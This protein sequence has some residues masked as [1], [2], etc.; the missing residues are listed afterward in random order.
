M[1]DII[2]LLPDS[3]AN[4]IAAGEV[5]QRPASA[6]KELLENSVDAGASLIRLVVKDA[7]RTLI[8]V[9]DN[10][11]G[12][13]E[14]DARMSFERHATSKIR[15]ADDLF[16]IRTK[17]FRGEALASIGAIAQV[18]LRTKQHGE[19]LGTLLVVEGSEVK[20]QEPCNCAEGTSF[21]VKNLFYNVPARRNFL[22]TDAVELRH[23]I[24]EFQRVALPHH[25]IGF[26]LHHNNTELFNLAPCNLRQ[27]IAQIF[28]SNYN[29]R[30]VPVEEET[31]IVKIKGFIGK[32]EFA[33][34]TR[35]EQ[36]FFINERFIR[37]AYL[38]HAVQMAY[39]E[40]LPQDSF[41]SY[42]ILMEVE[43]KSI[44]INIHPT[45]TEVKFE[46]EKFIY[47]ILRSAVKRSLGK[48]NISPTLDFEQET[49]FNVP[50]LPKDKTIHAP[51]IS[52]NPNYNPFAKE[53]LDKI[54]SSKEF[55]KSKFAEKYFSPQTAQGTGE[56]EFGQ[57][58]EK[59]L[60]E[61]AEQKKKNH[62]LHGRYILSHI[63]SGF[64]I[65]DQHAAHERILYERFSDM[66]EKQKAHSQQLLFPQHITFNQSDF[67]LA[68]ELLSEMRALGFDIEEFGKSTFIVQGVP[69]IVPE[70]NARQLLENLME[71]YKQNL[72]GLKFE[73]RESLARAM[74]QHTAIRPGKTL[75][76]QEMDAL[77]DELFACK[78]PY[79]SPSGNPTLIT[80]SLEDLEKRF[81][82]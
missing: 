78:M 15:N 30:V 5:I 73:K 20:T 32:P 71:Q 36:Y 25:N 13:S 52:V 41:P 7:G 61:G 44:D 26:S 49:S 79:S 43:P 28:G 75:S 72:T 35:G 6:V 45:K 56:K 19:A 47:S 2:R 57:H 53:E 81:K 1:A 33:R 70:N 10:G 58:V 64:M 37:N 12:M 46:D 3:V 17:G 63:K 69:A 74:A 55:L 27:R 22:K 4:Q 65:I 60:E 31:S 80:F 51:V 40:L 21:S 8:Q 66:L 9:I 82:K 18:E 23:I 39:E 24:E 48:Y 14:T 62:Q 76:E 38:H 34:R 68:K 59:G 11:K 77:V 67:E 42:F 50:P 16:N 29:E 54:P